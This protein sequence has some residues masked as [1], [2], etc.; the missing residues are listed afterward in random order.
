MMAH[1]QPPAISGSLVDGRR[2]SRQSLARASWS[3]AKSLNMR[4]ASAVAVEGI[5][6][7]TLAT[8]DVDRSL[9]FYVEILSCR[10]LARWPKGAYLLAGDMWLALVHGPD[11]TRDPA[12]YS[13]VAF[14]AHP[15]ALSEI[16]RRADAAGVETWQDNWTE[17]DSIYLTDPSGHRIEV[18]S[19]TLLD[20][21]RHSAEHPWEGLLIESDAIRIVEELSARPGEKLR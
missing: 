3:V 2:T 14:H 10:V 12:D 19:T 9:R 5:N 1:V 21:L 4:Q 13:H 7:L 8:A 18:H 17:G 16:R 15:V 6:H 11:E 20:R